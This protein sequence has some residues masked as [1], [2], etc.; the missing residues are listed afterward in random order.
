M[1]PEP[2]G[3]IGQRHDGEDDEIEIAEDHVAQNENIQQPRA[4]HG[5][6]AFGPDQKAR[7]EDQGHAQR[8]DEHA[9][10]APATLQHGA[11]DDLVD[12]EAQQS[13]NPDGCGGRHE[14]IDPRQAM[15]G[16]EG[17]AADDEHRSMGDVEDAQRREDQRKAN[18][19]QR[20]ITGKAKPA[21]E[22]LREAQHAEIQQPVREAIRAGFP[23][24]RPFRRPSPDRGRRGSRSAHPRPC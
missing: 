19:H 1:E 17:V 9:E 21:G 15:Q 4:R 13:R 20:V 8:G 14:E 11:I 24:T 12:G 16:E 2:Q 23:R 22:N 7:L 10:H 18:R 5:D 3:A 6:D